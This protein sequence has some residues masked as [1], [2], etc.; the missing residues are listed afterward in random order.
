M[1]VG[2]A[3]TTSGLL[4]SLRIPPPVVLIVVPL[5]GLATPNNDLVDLEEALASSLAPALELSSLPFRSRLI[6]L[7]REKST[8]TVSR[9]V[10][11][12]PNS[13]PTTA[14]L[15]LLVLLASMETEHYSSYNID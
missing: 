8:A 9:I 1:A 7:V 10:D 3:V 5:P 6:Y 4:L 12:P 14:S 13:S 2:E 15:I 11:V